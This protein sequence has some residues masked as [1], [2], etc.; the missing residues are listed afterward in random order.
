[1]KREVGEYAR[2]PH[3]LLMPQPSDGASWRMRG[4]GPVLR[5][6]PRLRFQPGGGEPLFRIART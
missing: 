5:M 2:K 3:V 1:M 4:L 6:Q